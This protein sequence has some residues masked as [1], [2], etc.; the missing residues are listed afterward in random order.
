MK[1]YFLF[2]GHTFLPNNETFL[3]RY[4]LDPGDLIFPA[5]NAHE[6]T[7]RT[8]AL[9]NLGTTPLLFDFDKDPDR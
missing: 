4:M 1:D 7:Y 9:S 8:L 5:V 3:P 6:P 2:L